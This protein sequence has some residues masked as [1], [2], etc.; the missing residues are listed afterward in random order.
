ME[1]RIDM[2]RVFGS[3]VSR[4]ASHYLSFAIFRVESQLYCLPKDYLSLQSE[5]F[6]GMFSVDGGTDGQSDD[7]PIVLE[8][9]KSQDFDALLRII[10]PKP[11]EYSAPNLTKPEWI[12]VLKLS[13]IWQMEKIRMLAINKLSSMALS[14]LEKITLAREYRIPNWLS[15]AV[16]DLAKALDTFKIEDLASAIGWE[17]TARIYAVKNA[18]QKGALNQMANEASNSLPISRL[19]CVGCNK[20]PASPAH[21]QCSCGGHL[22]K[23]VTTPTSAFAPQFANSTPERVTGYKISEPV[24]GP[25]K[26]ST[27]ED[28]P[29]ATAAV[30]ELFKSEIDEMV[31]GNAA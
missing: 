9:Y 20:P 3:S 28:G 25:Q 2:N 10:V 13:T 1:R 6:A 11:L 4:N 18:A 22:C 16:T 15:E 14:P 23:R 29:A 12:S 26:G 27:V 7:D 17:T 19:R 31:Q 8:G 24:A 30:H 5:V 21:T